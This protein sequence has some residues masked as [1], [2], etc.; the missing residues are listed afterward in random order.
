MYDNIAFAHCC[1]SSA[2][3]RRTA[4]VN[5]LVFKAYV[6][7]NERIVFIDKKPG[8]EEVERKLAMIFEPRD[9]GHRVARYFTRKN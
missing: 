9:R 6:M 8:I 3:I 2:H 4:A 5:S 7:N 1:L